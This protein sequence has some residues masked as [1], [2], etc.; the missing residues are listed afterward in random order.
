[1]ALRLIEIALPENEKHKLEELKDDSSIELWQEDSI[2]SGLLVRILIPADNTEVLMDQLEKKFNH[3]EGF[4][5][6]MLPVEATLP[7]P[8]P[9]P[10]EKVKELTAKEKDEKKKKE[11]TAFRISREELYSEILDNIKFNRIFVAMVVLSSIVA[12]IG[13]MRDNVAVVIGAMVIAPLLGPN[14]GLSFATALGDFELG[15]E[16]FKTNLQGVLIALGLAIIIG[17][18]FGVDITN[19]EI[20]SRTT[21]EFSDIILALAA[22]IAGVLALSSGVSTALIGV[23]VAVALL[24]PLVAFGLLIGSGNFDLAAGAFLLLATNLICVNLA[25][26][27]TFILQGI[28]PRTWWEA[29]K[30][31]KASKTALLLWSFLLIILAVVIYL[32]QMR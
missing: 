19:S 20:T 14:V 26:V 18:I 13:L 27:T 1:L 17:Y 4:R 10:D 11:K 23:M 32:S 25:S 28:R 30:A 24:P 6:V 29:K 15:K 2:N 12:A 3:V 16:A 21:V 5:V 7:R 8:E 9:K 31:K 22:G